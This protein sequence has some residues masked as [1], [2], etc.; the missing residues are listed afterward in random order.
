MI[1][2]WNG[3]AAQLMPKDDLAEKWNAFGWD[4]FQVNGHSNEDMTKLFNDLKFN[5]DS[6]PKV[7]LAKTTKGKG[8]S[9]IEGHGKWHHKIPNEIEMNKI[10]EELK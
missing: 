2:D 4:T 7:I 10:L 5:F 8:V 9:F 3:S 1:V 6:N